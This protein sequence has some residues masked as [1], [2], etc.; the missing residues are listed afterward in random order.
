MLAI[1]TDFHSQLGRETLGRKESP[2][3]ISLVNFHKTLNGSV[4]SV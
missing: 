2:K 1:S 4:C 3:D